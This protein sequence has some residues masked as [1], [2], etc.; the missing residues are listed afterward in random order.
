M[1]A[2][3]YVANAQQTV[4]A[5][6]G[7]NLST[8]LVFGILFLLCLIPLYFYPLNEKKSAEILE[9]LE[10]KRAFENPAE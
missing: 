10:E 8:N 5:L 9:S 3:G 7:I 1:G 6:G 2:T 4:S